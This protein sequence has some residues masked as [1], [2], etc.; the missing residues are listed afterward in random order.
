MQFS[1]MNTGGT[2]L[3][4]KQ[5]PKI[6]GLH[7]YFVEPTNI[8]GGFEGDGKYEPILKEVFN[9]KTAT[10]S[11]I[12]Q[13]QNST[14]SII[15]DLQNEVIEIRKSVADTNKLLNKTIKQQ[16]KYQEEQTRRQKLADRYQKQLENQSRRN[17]FGS[18]PLAKALKKTAGTVGN[19]LYGGLIDTLFPGFTRMGGTKLVKELGAGTV[20][21]LGT[22]FGKK[23]EKS[24][25]K[26]VVTNLGSN[27]GLTTRGANRKTSLSNIFKN[28]SNL[29]GSKKGGRTVT[30]EV[31]DEAGN[32]VGKTTATVSKSKKIGLI[33]RMFGQAS[34]YT[35]NLFK[36]FNKNMIT[37]P[38]TALSTSVKTAGTSLVRSFGTMGKSITDVAVKGVGTAMRGLGTAVSALGRGLVAL[39]S[40]PW[41]LAGIVGAIGIGATAFNFNDFLKNPEKH[42]VFQKIQNNHP[43][44]S[45]LLGMGTS[46]E[47]ASK[48]PVL[49]KLVDRRKTV[50]DKK[51]VGLPQGLKATN[52]PGVGRN[53][54]AM[55]DIVGAN[56]IDRGN[57]KPYVAMSSAQGLKLLDDS[58]R[59]SGVNYLYTSGM[60]GQHKGGIAN[61]KSHA[62]GGKV[63]VQTVGR[64][65]TPAEYTKLYKQGHF[66][67]NT[68]ALGYEYKRGQNT[69]TTP[70]EYERLYNAGKVTMAGGN[71]Y[72][73]TVRLSKFAGALNTATENVNSF[74][75]G[76]KST[77][78]EAFDRTNL[79][80]QKVKTLSGAEVTVDEALKEMSNRANNYNSSASGAQTYRT[81]M[82]RMANR[83]AT[84]T[85]EDVSYGTRRMSSQ[86]STPPIQ[87]NS[88]GSANVGNGV[89]MGMLE[90][91]QTMF[92]S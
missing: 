10:Q 78:V 16:Q 6:M 18:N 33:G 15:S 14:I 57:S 5:P 77:V 20:G 8:D 19:N 68:G 45:G 87:I 90:L 80:T 65:L 89:S 61:P 27:L 92:Q 51:N 24:V 26:Q 64:V 29:F 71:H 1:Q 85:D 44:L 62:G 22:L 31:L 43:V 55:E 21:L 23:F 38:S 25:Q 35:K 46:E 50:K 72:D 83:Y 75:T 82:E 17:N 49:N 66:G 79:S 28:I 7:N 9:L 84:T 73:F 12:L 63:D 40:N 13:F 41:A 76:L 2:A 36:S 52:V 37:K 81:Q 30:A 34:D 39:I 67:A 60:G 4:L 3:F 54:V 48:H 32:V 91:L 74:A 69:I 86:Y 11:S 58:L 42:P 70:A 53:V 88:N 59:S 47:Y 56:R